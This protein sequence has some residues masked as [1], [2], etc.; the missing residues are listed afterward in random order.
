MKTVGRN[1]GHDAQYQMIRRECILC[2]SV[3]VSTIQ[4]NATM[5]CSAMQHNATQC[6][7]QRIARRSSP[8][9]SSPVQ[10]SPVQSSPVQSSPVQS[11]PVQCN[12]MQCFYY[13]PSEI[14]D[15]REVGVLL[16]PRYD[17]CGKVLFQLQVINVLFWPH[18]GA[19][20]QFVTETL[21]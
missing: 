17:T 9:Q 15:W 8:V 5:Q 13:Q 20:E 14:S 1:S 6:I 3:I 2:V 7:S 12:S 21:Y 19:I 10:S 4:C 18:G 11:S 16:G